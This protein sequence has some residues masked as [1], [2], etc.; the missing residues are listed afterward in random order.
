MTGRN[1]LGG[2]VLAA[3]LPA[4][5]SETVAM[6]PSPPV[7]FRTDPAPAPATSPLTP[8]AKERSLAEVYTKALA[9]PGFAELG[10][11]VEEQVQF[12]AGARNT[13]G[14]DRVKQGHDDLFGAFDQRHFVA[15]RVWLTDSTHPLDSQALE[16]TMTGVQARPF[17]GI[18]PTGKSVAIKGLTLLWTNDDGILSDLHLYFDEEVLKA[19]LGGGPAEL[20]KLPPPSLDAAAP[21]LFER[22]GTPEETTNVAT[23]RAMIQALEDDKEAEF[24]ATMNDDV[25]LF[26]LDRAEPVRG[27]NAAR[28]YFKTM[29]NSIHLLDTVVRNAWGVRS[30]T[31][32]EYVITGLQRAPLP[33]VA[34]AAGRALHARFVDIAEFR[35]GKMARIWRYADPSTFASL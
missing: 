35:E 4:C 3:L 7:A 15:N 10:S 20:A 25:E 23:V 17:M 34:F 18:A 1:F 13:H 5:S 24:L 21:Q 6:W 2:C 33:R 28:E 26:T 11:M 16:W 32:T 22:A 8:T 19:Q 29:R 30:F 12:T 9:S 31:V 27:K 14:R